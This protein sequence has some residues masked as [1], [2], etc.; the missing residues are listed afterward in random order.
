MFHLITMIGINGNQVKV[1]PNSSNILVLLDSTFSYSKITIKG[2]NTK[3]FAF[4]LPTYHDLANRGISHSLSDDYLTKTER[5]ELHDFVNSLYNWYDKTPESKNLE[6]DGINLLSIINPFEFH[7][8]FLSNLITFF[9]IK[10]IIEQEKPH[11]IFVT[12]RLSKFLDSFF[13][14]KHITVL[15]DPNLTYEKGGQG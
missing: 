3:I 6:F 4:D 13:D 7:E 10:K 5:E 2:N 1:V 14:K 8:Y 12:E 15:N 11:E 9:S